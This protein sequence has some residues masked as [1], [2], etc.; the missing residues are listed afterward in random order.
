M[1]P[2]LSYG[3]E[4]DKLKVA[5]KVGGQVDKDQDGEAS[6]KLS[7]SLELELD[8]SEVLEELILGASPA[9][10]EKAKSLL[11]MK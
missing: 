4:G 5:V 6:V 3:M 8:G 10:L 9:L 1:K 7:N 11:G 2:E